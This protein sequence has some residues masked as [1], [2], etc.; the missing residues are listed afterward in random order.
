MLRSP[1]HAHRLLDA[2]ERLE[3]IRDVKLQTDLLD[4]IDRHVSAQTLRAGDFE[5]DAK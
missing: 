3:L 5:P 4:E 1:A 2:M